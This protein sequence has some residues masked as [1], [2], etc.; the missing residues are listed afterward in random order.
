MSFGTAEMK[1]HSKGLT[2]NSYV[3]F[4]FSATVLMNFRVVVGTPN[5]GVFRSCEGTNAEHPAAAI[6]RATDPVLNFMMTK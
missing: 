6:K 3:S 4:S 2:V 1:Q 5:D